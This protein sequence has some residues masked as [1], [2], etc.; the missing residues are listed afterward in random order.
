[1]EFFDYYT[2]YEGRDSVGSNGFNT[3]ISEASA[4]DL[5]VVNV[6]MEKDVLDMYASKRKRRL[7][8]EEEEHDDDDDSNATTTTTT[9]TATSKI[10][11]STISNEELE[12]AIKA[13]NYDNN[14]KNAMKEEED[15][16][17]DSL[18]LPPIIIQKE[19]P[20]LYMKSA[21]TPAGPRDAIR[22]E[23]KRRFNRGLFILDLRHMPA[24]CGVWPAFWLT[25][26]ANW[27]VNGE[28]DIVE[29]VNYQSVAKTAL[30]S[31]Q[32]CRMD[33]VPLG[34]KTG[35]WDEAIGIPDGKTGIPDMTLR[36]ATDC[37]VYNPH[38]WLNQ[39]CVAV[40]AAGD[41]LGIPLNNKGG[42]VYVL[43][44]DPEN[45]H[46]RAWVFS[47]HKNVPEN[48]RDTIRTASEADADDRV[49]PDPSLW[50]LPYGYFA[51][52]ECLLLMS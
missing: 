27:P 1:M 36:H 9:T 2:F 26:E 33:D 11:N 15:L 34:V 4:F 46:I 51:I 48:L 17:M 10:L 29:G 42:G 41:S 24:G 19:E 8:K 32:G 18:L 25:D 5:G 7:E 40:D 16:I 14:S 39:G 20:F 44:W 50:P 30:H 52:G 13:Q 47:P 12:V 38:Q 49:K 37:F 6:T 3:Y 45:R 21:P 23:G 35:T 43:E 31:T 28:I 22:L